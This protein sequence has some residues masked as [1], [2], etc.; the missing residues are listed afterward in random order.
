MALLAHSAILAL[1]SRVLPRACD[2]RQEIDCWVGL[3][4]LAMH[5]ILGQVDHER[6]LAVIAIAPVLDCFDKAAK[7]LLG[8]DHF[9]L[10]GDLGLELV[11]FYH[12][13]KTG[14][15]VHRVN[16]VIDFVEPIKI[17]RHVIRELQLAKKHLVDELGHVLARLPASERGAFPYSARHELEWPRLNSLSGGCHTDDSGLAKASMSYLKR[18]AHD[19]H[20]SRAVEGKVNA[21]FLSLSEP[22]ASWTCHWIMAVRGTELFGDLELALIDVEAVNAS[23]SAVLGR[24]QDG[25]TDGTQAPHRYRHTVAEVRVVHDGSPASGDTTT[26]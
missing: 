4:S 13:A 25:Q 3:S 7:R 2:A 6:H 21:P 5:L 10:V 24:L 9:Y 16:E 22:I 18:I 11:D 20:I 17:V 8:L 1:D 26:E 12:S 15:L 14:A 23:G 19:S